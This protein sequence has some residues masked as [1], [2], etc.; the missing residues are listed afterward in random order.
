MVEVLLWT[1]VLQSISVT[2]VISNRHNLACRIHFIKPSS[3]ASLFIFTHLF[4]HSCSGLSPYSPSYTT[5][6]SL[7]DDLTKIIPLQSQHDSHALILW[8]VLGAYFMNNFYRERNVKL[9][10]TF[11]ILFKHILTVVSCASTFK[12][13]WG[14]TSEFSTLCYSHEKSHYMSKSFSHTLAFKP[15][16]MAVEV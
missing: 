9:Q 15:H 12:Q 3:R 5:W 7:C 11:L 14:A 6:W 1:E 8:W 16:P 10:T 2:M 13:C 4:V